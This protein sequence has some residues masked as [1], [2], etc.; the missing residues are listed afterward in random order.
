MRER[1]REGKRRRRKE[2]GMRK[3]GIGVYRERRKDE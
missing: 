2:C 1:K 3:G